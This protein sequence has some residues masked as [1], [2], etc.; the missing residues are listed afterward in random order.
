[1]Q[2]YR[3]PAP[4]QSLPKTPEKPKPSLKHRLL[5]TVRV[6]NWAPMGM[7]DGRLFLTCVVCGAKARTFRR[8]ASW[9]WGDMVF[10]EIGIL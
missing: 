4:I 5:H 8:K 1:M 9:Q 7:R 6:G 2:T 3:V 10:S